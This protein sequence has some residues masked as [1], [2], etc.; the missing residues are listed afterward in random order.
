MGRL[1]TWVDK[2]LQVGE[3][4]TEQDYARRDGLVM[5]AL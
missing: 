2:M 3:A 4:D 5:I 1:T